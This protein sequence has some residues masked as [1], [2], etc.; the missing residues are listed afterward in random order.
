MSQAT[1]NA[2]TLTRTEEKGFNVDTDPA[3]GR[4]AGSQ[5]E[6]IGNQQE[7]TYR[8]HSSKSSI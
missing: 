8:A 2:E 6:N 7:R 4:D 1:N 3:G 5:S